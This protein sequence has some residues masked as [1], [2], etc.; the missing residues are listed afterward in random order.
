MDAYFSLADHLAAEAATSNAAAKAL[1]ELS[2][3]PH[4]EAVEVTEGYLSGS[5]I[6]RHKAT[7]V[8]YSV[9][10]PEAGGHDYSA[11]IVERDGFARCDYPKYID[12]ETI[13]DLAAAIHAAR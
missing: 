7:G 12:A 3:T 4:F 9:L 13:E 11:Y 8:H 6:A 2:G 5:I 1:G 10:P